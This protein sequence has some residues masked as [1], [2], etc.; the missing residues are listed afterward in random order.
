MVATKLKLSKLQIRDILQQHGN[1]FGEFMPDAVIDRFSLTLLLLAEYLETLEFL[2]PAARTLILSRVALLV[3]YVTEDS[4]ALGQLVFCDRRYIAWTNHT[5]YIDLV[6]GDH[7]TDLPTNPLET[8]AYNLNMIYLCGRL[9]IERR[10]GLHAKQ[11]A[12]RTMEEP[13]DICE[14]TPGSVP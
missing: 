8:I 11:H 10:S 14:R 5:G 4:A 9:R 6:T 12:E 7:I 1:K 3:K 2:E 13:E